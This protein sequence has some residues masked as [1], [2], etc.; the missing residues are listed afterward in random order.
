MIRHRLRKELA[1]FRVGL[2]PGLAVIGIVLAARTLGLLQPLEWLVYDGFLR[3]RPS[4]AIDERIVIVEVNEAD[5]RNYGKYP[6]IDRE[7]AFLLRLIA[8]YK[9]R[10]IALDIVRDLEVPPGRG[11]LIA[12]LQEIDGVFA[13]EKVLPE[14]FSPPPNLLPEKVGFSDQII[15]SD[16]KLR[17]SL[18]ATPTEKY[19][20]K[21]SLSL[22]LAERYLLKEGYKMENGIHNRDAIRFGQVELA[23]LDADAGGYVRADTGGVQVLL[24]F[25]SG[26]SRFPKISATKLKTG[27]F[28]QKLIQDRIVI[29]GVTAPSVK[30]FFPSSA[31]YSQKPTLGRVYGVEIQAHATSQIISAVLDGR[32]LIQTWPEFW[33]YLWI[34]AWGVAGISLARM[35]RSPLKNLLAVLVSIAI[36]LLSCFLLLVGGWW[37]P[38]IPSLL[39]LGLNGVALTALYQYEYALKSKIKARQVII[40]RTFETIHNGPLQT[41][42]RS[43]KRLRDHQA[44]KQI[45]VASDLMGEL[46]Q[47][48]EKLNCELRGIYE[49]L[50]QEPITQDNSLYLGQGT[51]LNLTDPLHEVLYQVYDH[52]LQ[53]D[54]P[55]FQTLR[56]NIRNF[57]PI[58][59]DNLSIEQKQG[60]CRFLEEALCNVGKH[61]HG[62]TRLDVNLS[63]YDGWY[64]LSII[65]D[66]VGENYHDDGRGAQ[67]C[68]NIAR[69]VHGKFRRSQLSPRGFLCELAWPKYTNW[70]SVIKKY[71]DR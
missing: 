25:R 61:A 57:E 24:N 36:L 45:G 29:I 5:I 53:R 49:F 32:S 31:I 4:E 12:A 30:D 59:S 17:R 68:R 66:G 41:L 18:L 9:P 3:L 69:Q 47:D 64:T 6:I 60:L 20:Y 8:S 11:E 21:F 38:L 15:D 71:F 13:I 52:T 51:V 10:A 56:F 42:A 7:L 43:L 44:N 2:L 35:T 55:C 22:R 63:L 67:Q 62:L 37:I 46:E 28:D 23:P 40:E 39:L 34:I 26:R 33:E 54:L 65:D 14:T 58:E 27:N 70:L 48:L 1:L 50:Q 16:G 19:G